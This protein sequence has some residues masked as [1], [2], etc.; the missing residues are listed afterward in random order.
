MQRFLRKKI[1]RSAKI[2]NP[3]EI[4]LENLKFRRSEMHSFEDRS[5]KR[6]KRK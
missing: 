6:I 3:N 4:S 5:R 1:S 2:K